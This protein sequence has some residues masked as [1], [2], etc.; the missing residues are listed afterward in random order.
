M[1]SF[2]VDFSVGISV[3][4]YSSTD[5]ATASNY[6][7]SILKKSDKFFLFL[8]DHCILKRDNLLKSTTALPLCN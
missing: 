8:V 2:H 4:R 3:Q 7:I 1:C 6:P 5:T